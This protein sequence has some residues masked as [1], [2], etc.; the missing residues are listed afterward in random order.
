[1]IVGLDT[2][3]ICYAMDPAYPEHEKLPKELTKLQL[4]EWGGKN[5]LF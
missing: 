2:N 1:M 4:V 3:I 5:V